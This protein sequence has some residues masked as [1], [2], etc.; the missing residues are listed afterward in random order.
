M[1]EIE[2][3]LKILKHSNFEFAN[4]LDKFL[5][6]QLKKRRSEKLINRFRIGE[7]VKDDPKMIIQNFVKYYK[8]LY[9]KELENPEEIEQY[10]NQHKIP[11]TTQDK[12]VKHPCFNDG[13]SKLGE[14]PGPNGIPV[15]YYKK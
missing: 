11:S 9:K 4:K 12:D 1:L 15:E 13:N 6:W 5:A 8:E 7:R 10:L 14:M 3:N 2:W